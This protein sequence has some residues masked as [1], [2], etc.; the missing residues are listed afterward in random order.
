MV[1][2]CA[3]QSGA[4]YADASLDHLGKAVVNSK[5][6]RYVLPLNSNGDKV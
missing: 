6:R 5:A 4:L 2:V 3:H 1:D